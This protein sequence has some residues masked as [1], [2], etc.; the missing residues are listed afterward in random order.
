MR[1]EL[2][3]GSLLHTH[4]GVLYFGGT[5]CLNARSNPSPVSLTPSFRTVSLNRSD[6]SALVIFGGRFGFRSDCSGVFG[7]W[8]MVSIISHLLAAREGQ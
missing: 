2:R 7:L 5:I 6:C 8:V 4:D 1:S 3:Q